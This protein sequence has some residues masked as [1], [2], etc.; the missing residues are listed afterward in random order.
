MRR[1]GHGASLLVVPSGTE[2]WRELIAQPT[3][4]AMAPPFRALAELLDRR[5]RRRRGTRCATLVDAI[6]GLTAVDG[7]AILTQRFELL[8][9]G[10]TIRRREG[11]RRSSRSS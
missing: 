10:A 8:A 11:T 2:G 7:A 4:Y 1:H 6:A 5:G 3:S 9:F